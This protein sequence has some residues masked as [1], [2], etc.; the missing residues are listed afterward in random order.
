MIDA[1]QRVKWKNILGLVMFI[2]I[3]FALIWF[4]T[5]ANIV[6]FGDCVE[7][8]NIKVCFIVNDDTI[9]RQ[10]ATEIITEVS[11]TGESNTD[12]VITMK[13]SPNLEGLSETQQ[14]IE[15]LAPGDKVKRSF[16]VAA[17]QEI[18]EFNI[19]FDIDSDLEGDKTIKLFVE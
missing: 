15:A 8:G 11:N 14:D 13:V 9:G 12:A 18:G 7:K 4:I 3:I 19:E 5:L 17:K 6:L 1:V 10:E 2:L 16:R